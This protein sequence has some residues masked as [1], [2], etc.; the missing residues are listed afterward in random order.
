MS[1]GRFR[2][3]AVCTSVLSLYHTKS[4]VS[5]A[6]ERSTHGQPLNA[7]H[8]PDLLSG[9]QATSPH[10]SGQAWHLQSWGSQVDLAEEL[11]T[12]LS[13]Y[14]FSH[15]F[16]CSQAKSGFSLLTLIC[17]IHRTFRLDCEHPPSSSPQCVQLECQRPKTFS[18]HWTRLE[19]GH[20]TNSRQHHV[21]IPSMLRY[22]AVFNYH[23]KYSINPTFMV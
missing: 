18:P 1:A 7:P 8:P 4:R 2:K 5:F 6:W 21:L 12:G 23:P 19:C 3:C 13:L 9:S 16:Q 14:Q 11:W 20:S 10:G 22:E 15:Q 17:V